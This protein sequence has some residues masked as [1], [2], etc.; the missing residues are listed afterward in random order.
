MP[1]DAHATDL[2]VAVVG[3]GSMGRGI[4]RVVAQ[5]GVRVLA[6]DEKPE[7]AKAAVAHIAKMIEAQVEKGRLAAEAGKP[8]SIALASRTTSLPWRRPTIDVRH[9]VM[10]RSTVSLQRGLQPLPDLGAARRRGS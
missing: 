6:F 8:R 9:A 5:G 1:F 3:T 2:L 7:A 4:M 10:E